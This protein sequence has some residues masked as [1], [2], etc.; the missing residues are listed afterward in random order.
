MTAQPTNLVNIAAP[1]VERMPE[2]VLR[3]LGQGGLASVRVAERH[4]APEPRLSLRAQYVW[5]R[6]GLAVSDCVM[7]VLAVYLAYRLRFDLQIALSPEVVGRPE[8]YGPLASGLLPLWLALFALFGLYSRRYL[9]GG[10]EEY[11]RAFNACTT[12]ILA[13]I[14]VAFAEPTVTIARGWLTAAWALSIL[15]VCLGRFLMRRLVYHLRRHGYFVHRAAIVGV[16][17]EAHALAEELR[18]YKASGLNMLGF[19]ASQ[20]WYSEGEEPILGS[21]DDICTTIQE[22][23]ISEVI[24]AATA[25][26]RHQLLNLFKE[27]SALPDVEL[28]LSSGLYEVLTTGVRVKQAGFVPL[29]T[30]NKVRLEPGEALVKTFMDYTLATLGVIA[31]LPVFALLALIIKLD[32]PG[33]VLYR[34]RVLGVCGK[35]FDALK[36][37]TM[38]VNG[39]EI[40]RWHP[41]LQAQLHANQKLKKDPRVTRVGRWLRKYSL[42]ELPQLF[43]VL[44]GQMSLVGPRMISPSEAALYGQLRTNLLTVKPGLSGLWQTSGRSD[45]S[46]EERIQLDMHYI[47]NY[48]IWRDLQ[49][50][51]IQ[52]VPAVLKGR[53]AY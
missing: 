50:L 27:A 10:I 1:D 19:I 37:R 47:R 35:E 33:P 46:Y 53:G 38:H 34:R 9:I 4:V 20:A 12:G 18:N 21:I 32:S 11:A 14:V 48:T 22:H 26:D 40:L 8:F 43:N 44:L 15:L 23:R 39:D 28:R 49:I 36:F 5:L 30:L 6:L 31:L 52:T 41:D 24:V 7:L 29:M 16:N 13:V 25:L 51:F 17:G 42:D 3:P 2:Y 45:V